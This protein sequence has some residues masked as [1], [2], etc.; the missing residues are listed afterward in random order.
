MEQGPLM[1]LNHIQGR[2]NIMKTIAF[3]AALVAATITLASAST[4]VFA[5]PKGSFGS[6][7]VT[8]QAKTGRYCFKDVVTGSRI[9]VTQC[10]TQEEWAK[11]GLT[12]TRKPAVQLARR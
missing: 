2:T 6:T 9:P 5:Q 10:R 4:P 8:Y 7:K 3:T 11:A 1:G 12:I